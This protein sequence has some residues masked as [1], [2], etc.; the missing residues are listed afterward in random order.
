MAY[1]SIRSFPPEFAL[2]A[3]KVAETQ[4][5]FTLEFPD[6]GLAV[7]RA[8]SLRSFF[9]ML[10]SADRDP[11]TPAN[12]RDLAP[13]CST[14]YVVGPG[15]SRTPPYRITVHPHEARTGFS[16]SE[17]LGDFTPAAWQGAQRAGVGERETSLPP[18]TFEPRATEQPEV[19]LPDEELFRIYLSADRIA[20][21]LLSPR[22]RARAQDL[23]AF[24]G[25]AFA[26][27]RAW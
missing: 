7:N 2:L 14:M 4:E 19:D 22:Q 3:W 13:H 5:P 16:I 24:G 12:L 11:E 27:P 1:K 17:Q 15:R 8:I 18:D 20:I 21:A 6:Y 9:K 10:R 25:P 26:P 23:I